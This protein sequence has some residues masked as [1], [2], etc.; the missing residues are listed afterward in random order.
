MN[1]YKDVRVRA[2]WKAPV[3]VCVANDKEEAKEW[4]LAETARVT[5]FSDGSLVD[6]MVGAAGLLCV[7]G[8]VKRAKGLQLG[9]AE[10]YGIFEAEG[11]GQILAIECL[12]QETGKDIEG[13]VPLGLD[14][15]AAIIT[16][17]SGKPGPGH[18][19]WDHFHTRLRKTKQTHPRIR[20]RIDW[21]PGH[22]DIPGNEAA[23]EA[24]K[25]AARE[26]SFGGTPKVL[27]NLPYSKSALTQT[28]AQLLKVETR[29]Q[30]EKSPRYSRIK[31]IDPSVP[32]NRFLKTISTFPCKHAALL[33]QLHTH[34][35]PLAKHLHRLNKAPSPI[36][37][38]CERDIETVDHYLHF[39]PAHT[40]AH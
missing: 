33:F 13:I 35:I 37:P 32:S 40:H 36:C 11:V 21:T 16:T 12:R 28:H 23:D 9:T 1:T 34:H 30:F 29:K 7:N 22:V 24:A 8:E 27:K 3:E 19:I 39:C 14:N 5:L 4:A 6:G 17:A 31:D 38:C 18:Y 26:G 2:G 20:L 10:R 15:K 25:R